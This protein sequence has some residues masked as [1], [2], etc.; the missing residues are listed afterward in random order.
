[1]TKHRQD[2]TPNR[3][4]TCCKPQLTGTCLAKLS[5]S[6][7]Q[8]N[9]DGDSQDT[10][11]DPP[12]SRDE[13]LTVSNPLSTQ[14]RCQPPGC[15]FQGSVGFGLR[16][17]TLRPTARLE[18]QLLHSLAVCVPWDSV[19]ASAKW[20][21]LPPRLAV[22]NPGP[23]D[24]ESSLRR[25][26]AV[27]AVWRCVIGESEHNQEE[28]SHAFSGICC[29]SLQSHSQQSMLASMLGA[30]PGFAD[31]DVEMWAPGLGTHSLPATLPQKGALHQATRLLS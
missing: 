20:T 2:S 6:S 13:L 15:L 1:M 29:H 30:A 14:V 21:R 25:T 16:A 23:Q 5:W 26:R 8:G 10:C 18:F 4:T 28:G 22:K 11:L 12:T 9:S 17:E 19:F 24:W 7:A 27:E 3:K 31:G